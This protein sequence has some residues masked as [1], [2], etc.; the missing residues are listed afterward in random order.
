MSKCIKWDRITKPSFKGPT[1][2]IVRALK[3]PALGDEA[4]IF[5]LTKNRKAIIKYKLMYLKKPENKVKDLG[6]FRTIAQV[7]KKLYKSLPIAQ[8]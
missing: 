5:R 2:D 4:V 8:L 6:D 3:S 7:V 1:A